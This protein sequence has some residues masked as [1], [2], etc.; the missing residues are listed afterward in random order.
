MRYR[1][2][3][4]YWYTT[5][6]VSE[7]SWYRHINHWTDPCPVLRHWQ[8]LCWW[9]DRGLKESLCPACTDEF[10]GNSGG[11]VGAGR[12]GGGGGAN[13][14]WSSYAIRHTQTHTHKPSRTHPGFLAVELHVK[15]LSPSNNHI[16]SCQRLNQV[17]H[18]H[19][20][21]PHPVLPPLQGTKVVH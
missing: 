7:H 11:G 3:Y 1:V 4:R 13:R 20:S 10:I 15:T 21:P 14:Q 16:L 12:E 5:V 18:G 6:C 2:W 19:P 17:L 8:S 9:T